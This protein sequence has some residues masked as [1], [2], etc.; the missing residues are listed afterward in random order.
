MQNTKSKET[1]DF[2]KSNLDYFLYL[3]SYILQYHLGGL[4]QKNALHAHDE[5]GE[6]MDSQ[7]KNAFL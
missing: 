6:S 7:Y 5:T 2:F 3:K 1:Y 4:G